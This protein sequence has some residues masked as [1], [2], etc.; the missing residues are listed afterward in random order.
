MNN[1]DCPG[2]A[3]IP[4]QVGCRERPASEEEWQCLDC[5]R[6][7]RDGELVGIGGRRFDNGG[8]DE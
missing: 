3:C 2:A 1:E 4:C 6:V 8:D 5:L 7:W